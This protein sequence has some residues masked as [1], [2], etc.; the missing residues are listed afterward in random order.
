MTIAAT[1]SARIAK[2]IGTKYAVA[3]GVGVATASLTYMAAVYRV[4]T[5]YEL[6]MI[7]QIL[8]GTGLGLAISP[9][10][11]SIMGAIPV[12]KAGVGSAMNN[13]IRQLGGALGIAVLGTVMNTAYLSNLNVV[14]SQ[15]SG[16]S[17][18]GF[19]AI[20]ESIQ[21]AHT[22]AGS[23]GLS[24]SQSQAIIDAANNAFVSAMTGAILV[25]AVIM[26]FTVLLTLWIL[27]THVRP[28][29]DV[30]VGETGQESIAVSIGH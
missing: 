4:G 14:K 5:P 28:P 11:N 26:A 15:L 9:A 8:L 17:E 3:L 19:A 7:G 23:S 20:S 18:E 12:R 25:G 6:V 24:A 16:L 13:T 27:P 1:Y 29:E 2:C 30:I 22:F 10:T 21:Q